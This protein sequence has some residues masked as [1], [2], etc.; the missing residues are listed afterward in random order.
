MKYLQDAWLVL[1]LALVFGG[2]LAAVHLGLSGRIEQNKV[3]ETYRAIPQLVDGAVAER[4]EEVAFDDKTAYKAFDQTGEHIGWVVP[5]RQSGYSGPI[6]LLIGLNPD[7]T[8][9][10]GLY[11]LSHIETPG[12]GDKIATKEIDYAGRFAG[13]SATDTLTLTKST[14]PPGSN[15]IQAITGATVSSLAV[16]DGVNKGVRRFRRAMGFERPPVRPAN[17]VHA[18]FPDAVADDVPTYDP[19]SAGGPMIHR[20][21][22]AEGRTLGWVAVHHGTGYNKRVPVVVAVGTD[23]AGERIAGLCVCRHKDGRAKEGLASGWL[24]RFEGLDASEAIRV[25]KD[26]PGD[27][28]ANE[29]KAITGATMT[30]RSV[31]KIATE[32]LA[33]L[34]ERI[35]SGAAGGGQRSSEDNDGQ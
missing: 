14:P 7:A 18:I 20:A 15:Q 17:A 26:R 16:L 11:V 19:A 23:E 21:R 24:K 25:V 30:S 4:T 29:I 2:G 3:E 34:R 8:E 32:A 28:G 12:L 13:K 22:D 31:A 35:A 27:E 1:T 5:A 33:A 9:I 10:I 6:D